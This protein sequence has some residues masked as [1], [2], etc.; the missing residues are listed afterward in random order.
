MTILGK[1]GSDACEIRGPGLGFFWYP[2]IQIMDVIAIQRQSFDIENMVINCRT[3][4]NGQNGTKATAGKI[5]YTKTGVIEVQT[6]EISIVYKTSFSADPKKT[7]QTLEGFY[8][9]STDGKIDHKT[10]QRML[11]DVVQQHLKAEI[12]K[13]TISTVMSVQQTLINTIKDLVSKNLE[14]RGLPIEITDL[15][16]NKRIELANTADAEALRAKATARLQLAAVEDEQAVEIEKAKLQ[17]VVTRHEAEALAAKMEVLAKA[18]GFDE[19]PPAS[20]A[21]AWLTADTIKAYEAI[22]TSSSSKVVM[23]PN[24]G[25]LLPQV[26]N[27]LVDLSKKGGG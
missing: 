27:M 16:L 12:E 20:V 1:W 18:Y 14:T 9:V 23:L 25:S 10:I 21:K 4:T 22:G 3:D 8:E 5:D 7:D 13:M 15:S 26:E 19:L 2:F 6:N 11:K 24:I 17:I